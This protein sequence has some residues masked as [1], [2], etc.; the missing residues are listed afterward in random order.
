MPNKLALGRSEYGSTPQVAYVAANSFSLGSAL[1]RYRAGNNPGRGKIY[2][3]RTLPAVAL[4]LTATILPAQNQKSADYGK[5]QLR[6]ALVLSR[7]GIRPPL[8]AASALDLHSSDPWPEWEVPL[9]YLTPH[10]AM[11]IHQMGAY[12]RL[13]FARNGLLPAVGCPNSNEIYLYADTD[14][15]NIESSRNTFAGLEPGCDPRPINTIIPVQGAKDALFSPIPSS[16][17]PP[18]K[19][20]SASDSQAATGKDPVAF[21]SL[22]GNPELKEFAHILAPDPAHPAVKTILNDPKPLSAASS[23]VED[24]LLE[25]VDDKPMSEVGWGRVDERMLRRLIPL[26]VKQFAST[27]RTP[28]SARTQGSNLMAHILDT[29]EQ[30]AQA[31]HNPSAMPIPG[32]I[33]P[34]GTHLVYISA[35]DSN[36]FNIGGLLNLHWNADGRTDD[37]PPDSQIVFELWQNP[38]SKE[39][40]VHLR[41]RAQTIDQLRSGQALTLA[42]PPVEVA[43]TP[44]GCRAGAPCPFAVFDHAAHDLLDPAY[45]KPDLQ[46]TQ[47]VPRLRR[48]LA[49][50]PAK[51]R[52]RKNCPV[53]MVG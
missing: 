33:G 25:Y 3:M 30:A 52:L 43:L 36:L 37:T 11:A 17:P 23:M 14:E 1:N 34:V 24:V 46:P 31:S 53:S 8:T 18:L 9:G 35:H 41:Y 29:L 6:F 49:D 39:Y 40:T 16:F 50:G 12:M 13:D 19:D 32:A 4:L 44:S 7:H 26:H 15:R 47:V 48:R 28:L 2:I 22:T 21:F 10:G 45:I 20:V 38:K 5:D 51:T 42:N 27:T